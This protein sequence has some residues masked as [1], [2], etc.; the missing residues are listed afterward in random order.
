MNPG[1]WVSLLPITV[2]LTAVLVTRR[3]LESMLA[4]IIAG[5][6]LT[7]GLAFFPSMLEAISRVMQDP[8]IGFVILL[9]SSMGALVAVLDRSGGTRGF[10]DR[11][12]SWVSTRRGVLL[13]TWVMSLF[14]FID[15]FLIS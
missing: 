13:A 12:S 7:D 6:I 15:D 3:S 2:L 9:C 8:T 5:F 10:G 1:G 14:I 11:V 4:A